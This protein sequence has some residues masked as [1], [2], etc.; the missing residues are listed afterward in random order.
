MSSPATARA[1]S[2]L[3]DAAER[4]PLWK[5]LVGERAARIEWAEV[6]T[7]RRSLLESRFDDSVADRAVSREQAIDHYRRSPGK[8][9]PSGAQ[10]FVS[11]GAHGRP[12][13]VLSDTEAWQANLAALRRALAAAGAPEDGRVALV[14]SND[15]AHTLPRLRPLDP[16]GEALVIG[17]QDSVA[18]ARSQLEQARPDVIFGIASAIALLADQEVNV[19]PAA[20]LTSTDGL[21]ARQVKAVERAFGVTPRATYS[22][23][24][25]GLVASQC[26]EG[27]DM[28]VAA[29]EVLVEET[30]SGGCATNLTNRLQPAIKMLLPEGV[31]LSESPCRCG[32]S[33]LRLRL[34]GGRRAEV[35]TLPAVGGGRVPV[36]PIVFRSALDPLLLERL[37][38]VRWDGSR[39]RVGVEGEAVEEARDRLLPA[40]ARAGVDPGV[41]TVEHSEAPV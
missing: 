32:G 16:R 19:S 35:L 23:T 5:E 26:R 20:V 29:E 10:V 41:L 13:P 22:T 39:L 11:A 3:E 40:L 9:L 34:Q 4:V 7:T 15:P 37:P 33:A 8:P 28:H 21:D 17:L 38:S 24:E 31:F 1:R 14:G 25:L 27:G 2:L 12:I 6:P 30:G 36:H 18:G